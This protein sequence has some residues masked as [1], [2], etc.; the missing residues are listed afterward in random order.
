MSKEFTCEMCQGTFV[1][2]WTEE[3]AEKEYKDTFGSPSGE[4]RAI[5]CDDCHIEFMKWFETNGK[6]AAN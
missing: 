6:R 5:L 1:S 3:E 2:T 4:E